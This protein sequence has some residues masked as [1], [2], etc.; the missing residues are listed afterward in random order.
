MK[1]FW[2][3]TAAVVV[4][5]LACGFIF[6]RYPLWVND[7]V[8]RYHLWRSG[9]RS[10]YVE[11]DGNRVHYFEAK[12]PNGS[13]GIPLVLVHGLG[14]RGEDWSRMIPALAAKGFHV[15][16][17]DLLGYGRS[18]KPDVSYSITMEEGVAVDYMHAMGL[19]R[20]DVDGWSM[21]G[22]IAAKL[23]LDHPE[24][25]DR[26][27][28]DDSAGLTFKPTFDRTAFVPANPVALTRLISML[29]PKPRVLPGFVVQATLRRVAKMGWVVQRSMDS[30]EAGGDLLDSRLGG[31]TQ[32]TLIVWGMQDN[33]IPVSVGEQM[34]RDIRGSNFV[35]ISGCGHL[36][37]EEC[38]KPVLA[39]TIQFLRSQ[40]PLE[41]VQTLLA[42]TPH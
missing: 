42:G 34:H 7:Q 16:V 15:Y 38:S 36:A 17:P 10:A 31:I 19:L 29:S 2:R 6:Y 18:A 25:V 33:L 26:L 13:A 22:W 41:G 11:V 14:A 4:L 1:T 32:P 3:G 27:V 23:A 30:M 40:P 12:P 9:V 21:G 20:A 5:V 24:M 35:G 28:L 37:A 8:I 39:A